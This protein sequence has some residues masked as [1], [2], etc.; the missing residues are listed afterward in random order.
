MSES[1]IPLN[2]AAAGGWA[3]LGSNQAHAQTAGSDSG[4]VSTGFAGTNGQAHT[5]N[6]P[7][8]TTPVDRPDGHRR[9]TELVYVPA[10]GNDAIRTK[11][12]EL[13][14]A[15]LDRDGTGRICFYCG[16][17]GSVLEHVTPRGWRGGSDS[18]DNLVFACPTCNLCKGD[19]PG[20]FFVFWHEAGRPSRRRMAA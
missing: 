9:D 12:W 7:R 19:T 3:H 6:R 15:I 4:L 17:P 8:S 16:A 13:E 14:R 20:W 18:I 5:G 10:Q 1:T 2:H 11:R